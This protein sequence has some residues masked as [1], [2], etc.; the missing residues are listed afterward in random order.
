MPDT[1]ARA[2]TDEPPEDLGEPTAEIVPPRAGPRFN[3]EPQRE[4]MRGRLALSAFI[5]LVVCIVGI[6]GVVAAGFRTWDQM[7]GVTASVLPAVL[8]TVSAILGFYF[9]SRGGRNGA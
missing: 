6:L 7:E 2:P 3:P 8:S 1:R 9:G 5:L 4:K